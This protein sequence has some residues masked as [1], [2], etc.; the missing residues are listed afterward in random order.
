[1]TP[2]LRAARVA[3]GLAAVL[4]PL[5]HAALRAAQDDTAWPTAGA[6]V[7]GLLV[8]L[9]AGATPGVAVALA[10]APLWP[11]VMRPRR[12]ASVTISDPAQRSRNRSA[13][14]RSSVERASPTRF[15]PVSVS[16]T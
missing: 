14:M 5:A 11:V 15:S 1:M 10:L 12:S 16:T 9:L 13:A 6:V 7:A 8:R 2:A 4:L 3:V